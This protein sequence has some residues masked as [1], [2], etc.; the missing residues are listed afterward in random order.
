MRGMHTC[1]VSVKILSY[2][3]HFRYSDSGITGPFRSRKSSGKHNYPRSVRGGVS[4]CAL[5]IMV[6][7]M[8]VNMP[9]GM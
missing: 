9:V 5:A 1:V 4:Q 3:K 7:V 2:D 8:L 6:G